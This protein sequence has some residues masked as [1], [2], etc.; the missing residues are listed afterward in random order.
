MPYNHNEVSLSG[1]VGGSLDSLD[2]EFEE[3][4][5]FD[6]WADHPD[7]HAN[8]RAWGRPYIDWDGVPYA[9]YNEE[10]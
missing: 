7:V 8:L 5:R 1:R 2:A 10:E 9:S 3:G 6:A 4:G